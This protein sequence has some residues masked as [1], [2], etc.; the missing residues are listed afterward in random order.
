MI[1]IEKLLIQQNLI[2]RNKKDYKSFCGKEKVPICNKVTL[3]IEE[4]C[5]KKRV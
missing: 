1:S 5:E 3:T 4:A 2:M